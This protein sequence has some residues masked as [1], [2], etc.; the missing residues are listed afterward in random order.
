MALEKSSRS[1]KTSAS[2][3]SRSRRCGGGYVS[4]TWQ[5]EDAFG[6]IKADALKRL[7]AGR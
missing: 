1:S 6:D 2:W 3:K 5:A 7:G 4:S